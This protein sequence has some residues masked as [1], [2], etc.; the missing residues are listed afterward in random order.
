M[1]QNFLRNTYNDFIEI[2]EMHSKS[3]PTDDELNNLNPNYSFKY[4]KPPNKKIDVRDK[5]F[6]KH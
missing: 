4:K 2:L 6:F 5:I 3:L 1:L